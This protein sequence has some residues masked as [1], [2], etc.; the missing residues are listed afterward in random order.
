MILRIRRS[1][2]EGASTTKREGVQNAMERLRG[3]LGQ[4]A[5]MTDGTNEWCVWEDHRFTPLDAARF[6]KAFGVSGDPPSSQ[7]DEVFAW[8]VG[9]GLV[10]PENVPHTEGENR[11]QEIIDAQPGPPNRI[12]MGSDALIGMTPVE[13]T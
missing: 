10:L 2:Y 3:A 9:Q 7:R 6:G 12:V 4:P 11:W 13:T 5:I 8:L 1:T